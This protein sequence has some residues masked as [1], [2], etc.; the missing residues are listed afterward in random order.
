MHF[1]EASGGL[2]GAPVDRILQDDEEWRQWRG[3]GD[4]VLHIE[5]RRWADLFV[6]APLR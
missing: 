6:I 1:V 2:D 4:D 3:K 5:L